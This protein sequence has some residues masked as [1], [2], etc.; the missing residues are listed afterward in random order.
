MERGSSMLK[1]VAGIL[2]VTAT[3]GVGG[4]VCYADSPVE[5]EQWSSTAVVQVEGISTLA[6]AKI[7]QLQNASTN[8]VQTQ[9]GNIG[10]AGQGQSATGTGVQVQ[11]GVTSGPATA[12]Q[13][14]VIGI[15]MGDTQTDASGRTQNQ[16][17]GIIN[18]AAQTTNT[19][20]SAV[21]VQGG[22]N[23]VTATHFQLSIPSGPSIQHQGARVTTSQFQTA[24]ENPLK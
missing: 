16:G 20:N 3:L 11:T 9:I 17:T 8:A 1:K 24:I 5:Q 22:V 12:V 13:G 15:A 7:K 4:G 10:G 18:T 21:I 14:G 23:H 19:Q 6:P 2:T